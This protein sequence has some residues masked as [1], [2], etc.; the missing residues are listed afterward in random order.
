MSTYLCSP[1]AYW[2]GP[3]LERKEYE[4]LKEKI[5]KD[6]PMAYSNSYFSELVTKEL[7]PKITDP[8]V[9]KFNRTLAVE[10]SWVKSIAYNPDASALQV[11]TTRD[12]TY[13][14]MGVSALTWARISTAKSIGTAVNDELKDLHHL[15]M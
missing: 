13:I 2:F 6:N 7:A 14:Y 12:K 1:R 5:R 8:V 9:I 10:S 11:T 3:T 4:K 15:V